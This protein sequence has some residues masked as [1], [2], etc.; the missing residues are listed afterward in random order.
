MG[1]A[2]GFA[3]SVLSQEG[4]MAVY[5]RKLKCGLRYWFKFKMAGQVYFSP[6]EHLTSKAAKI[7]EANKIKELE[8]AAKLPK[9]VVKEL[10][11][12]EIMNSRLTELQKKRKSSEYYRQNQSCYRKFLE[13]L[14]LY[15]FGKEADYDQHKTII[16]VSQVTKKI[17]NDFLLGQSEEYAGNGYTNSIPNQQL[18]LIRA[19]FG[20]GE[21]FFDLERNPTKGLDLFPVDKKLKR[22]PTCKEVHL[23]MD[24]C[25]ERQL[26]LI[27]FLLETGA[28]IGE[29]LRFTGNDIGEG[30]VTLYTRKNRRGELTPRK[31]PVRRDFFQGLTFEPEDRIFPDWGDGG[32]WRPHFLMRKVRKLKQPA[33]NFHH[34]RHYFASRLC[35]ERTPLTVIQSYL[36]H[37]TAEMTSRYLQSLN[38]WV[39]V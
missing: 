23:V 16:P 39:R 13:F 29:A 33:W 36:G 20:H 32:E 9:L 12:L 31:V 2:F 38:I 15:L 1:L 28:R 5:P 27:D 37:S 26:F 34:C 4:G 14:V 30:F 18:R 19:L 35:M 8:E 3:L 17:I 7:A 22:I 10:T 21:K 25:N 24:E 11:I 6:A